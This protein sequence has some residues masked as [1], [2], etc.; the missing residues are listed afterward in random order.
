MANLGA[1]NPT[2]PNGP[3]EHSP[4]LRP[5]A[6]ALGHRRSLHPRGLKGRERSFRDGS[7]PGESSRG[8][9][10]RRIVAA[11]GSQGIGLRPH[12]WAGF[13]RPVGPERTAISS[14]IASCERRDPG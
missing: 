1:A 12:P 6:D 10:G 13:S 14:I 4:G 8:P 5:K 7:A 2:R 9:S 3:G 11:V